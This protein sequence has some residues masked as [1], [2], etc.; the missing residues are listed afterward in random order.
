MTFSSILWEVLERPHY[1]DS[2]GIRASGHMDLEFLWAFILKKERNR[3][4]VAPLFLD[5]ACVGGDS[6]QVV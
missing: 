1:A 6:R 4:V 5:V 3:C 2:M